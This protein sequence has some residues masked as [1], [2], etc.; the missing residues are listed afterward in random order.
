MEHYGAKRNERFKTLLIEN[1]ESAV[2]DILSVD[3]ATDKFWY[4]L[5]Q[6][7]LL[8]GCIGYREYCQICETG[9]IVIQKNFRYIHA[10]DKEKE[11]AAAFFQENTKIRKLPVIDENGQLLYEYVRSVEA[12]Y[13]DLDIQCGINKAETNKNLRREKITVS[14]TSYGKRLDLV[15]IAIKS[16]MAQTMKADSI[17]LYLAQ[18]DSH[19]KIKQEEELL[20]AGLRI[21]RNVK[22]LKSHKKYFY[23]VQEYPENLII[24]VDDDAIYDDRLIEDLYA[25]HLKYPDAVICR[26]GHRITKRNGKVSSYGLWESCVKSAMPEKGI[27]AIGVGGVLYPCGKYR[28]AFLDEKGIKETSLYGDDLWLKAV[29]LMWGISTY[30]I[31]EFSV[32]LIEGSQEEALYKENAENKRNDVYLDRLQQYFKI[33]FATL[34]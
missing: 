26:R 15:H 14:L 24:T 5:C 29:E 9:S 28:E 32:K 8:V 18:E 4:V 30:T 20:N 19:G 23:T 31:G 2:D 34:F 13:E 27:C 10:G 12:Y 11:E 3:V 16:I 7:G 22:D 6:N 33:N 25:E 17:V 21:A 1:I